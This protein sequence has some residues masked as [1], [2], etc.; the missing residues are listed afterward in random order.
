[1][2]NSKRWTWCCRSQ[3]RRST[4]DE[5]FPTGSDMTG[6]WC[7]GYLPYQKPKSVYKLLADVVVACHF[8]VSLVVALVIVF[9]ISLHQ[10]LGRKYGLLCHF[11]ISAVAGKVWR[12]NTRGNKSTTLKKW[13]SIS[14]R[15]CFKRK[16]TTELLSR[17][18]HQRG[19]N[20]DCLTPSL[21]Q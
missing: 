8:S 21:G 15:T 20:Y 12:M 1:M 7:I 16:T 4:Q 10:T 5:H 3:Q 9:P 6:S 17:H 13:Q 14:R 11:L 18:A 2:Q 19:N